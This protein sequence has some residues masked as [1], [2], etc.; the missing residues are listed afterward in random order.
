MIIML[1]RSISSLT[2][3]SSYWSHYINQFHLA[4]LPNTK[5]VSF[6][7]DNDNLVRIAFDLFHEGKLAH[8]TEGSIGTG[9]ERCDQDS[10]SERIGTLSSTCRTSS[11][12]LIRTGLTLELDKGALLFRKRLLLVV[13]KSFKNALLPQ[14][15]S[16]SHVRANCAP[17]KC[18]YL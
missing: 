17:G 15:A 13:G 7:I 4:T 3:F 8:D 6:S 16:N 12:L 2:P 9:T 11:L 10:Q 18:P 14:H 1:S 5:S